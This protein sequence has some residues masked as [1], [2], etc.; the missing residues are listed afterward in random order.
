MEN[1]LSS[2]D[3]LPYIRFRPPSE[4]LG[5]SL[6]TSMKNSSKITHFEGLWERFFTRKQGSNNNHNFRTKASVLSRINIYHNRSNSSTDRSTLSLEK[7]MQR[8][9]TLLC[10]PYCSFL[11][12]STIW[13]FDSLCL[14]HSVSLK[15]S[16]FDRNAPQ[17]KVYDIS[18]VFLLFCPE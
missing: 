5:S 1:D 13:I 18:R 9:L 10:L 2:V 11:K 4:V 15:T 12:F 14:F 8:T 17:S 6:T 7:T 3:I 16:F